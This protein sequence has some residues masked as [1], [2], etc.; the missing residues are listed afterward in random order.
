MIQGLGLDRHPEL[1]EQYF[2]N[3]HRLV[4][5]SQGDSADL[6]ERARGAAV[7]LGLEFEH[8]VTGYGQLEESLI[9]VAAPTA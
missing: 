3:Y 7:Q 5:L 9:K 8:V 1:L 6:L 4:Y 2:E